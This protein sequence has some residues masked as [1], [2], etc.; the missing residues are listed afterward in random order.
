MK[1]QQRLA[2]ILPLLG[3]RN[4]IVVTD[5]AYPAQAQPGIETIVA[6]GELI[7][8]LESVLAQVSGARHVRP[9]VHVDAELQFV[10]EQ[11][12]PGVSEFR[13]R[14]TAALDELAVESLPHE[15]I[16]ER[17]DEAGRIFRILVIKTNATIPYTS[18]FLRLDCGYWTD[19]AERRLRET[20]RH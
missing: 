15:A 20:I 4:W 11:D 19:D 8:V 9:V 2:D 13:R 16:I 12:A 6:N 3:H 7:A 1:W 17:L 10:A 5:A 14:L 18:V